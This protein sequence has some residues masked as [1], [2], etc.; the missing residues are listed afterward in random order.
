MHHAICKTVYLVGGECKVG[1]VRLRNHVKRTVKKSVRLFMRCVPLGKKLPTRSVIMTIIWLS[2]AGYEVDPP[3]KANLAI[4][5]NAVGQEFNCLSFT[6]EMPFKVS[7]FLALPKHSCLESLLP[8]AHI[9]SIVVPP[10]HMLLHQLLKALH[11]SSVMQ[12]TVWAMDSQLYSKCPKSASHS[13][14]D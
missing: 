6:L 13:R 2:S 10:I 8:R 1:K 9:L 7:S 3:G 14:A 12:D 5:S 4:G 11:V